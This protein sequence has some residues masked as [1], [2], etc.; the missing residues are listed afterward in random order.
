MGLK[1]KMIPLQSAYP[2]A[3]RCRHEI[4]EVASCFPV[5]LVLEREVEVGGGPE[6]VQERPQCKALTPVL[7][8][9][10][11]TRQCS[12]PADNVSEATPERSVVAK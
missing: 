10:R 11:S 2:I 9:P 6:H 5:F 8:R 7:L 12:M 4:H 3:F 1:A